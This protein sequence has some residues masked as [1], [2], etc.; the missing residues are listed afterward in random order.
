MGKEEEERN[1]TESFQ[2]QEHQIE[3]SGSKR[4]RMVSTV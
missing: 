2:G 1:N 4:Y 3:I